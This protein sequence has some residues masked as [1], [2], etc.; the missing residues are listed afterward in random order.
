MFD[1]EKDLLGD[2]GSL[3]L[4]R[5]LGADFAEFTPIDDNTD[6]SSIF[7]EEKKEAQ[8]QP[9]PVPQEPPAE[10]AG[11]APIPVILKSA[12]P[13][14]LHTICFVKGT[15]SAVPLIFELG[16]RSEII[17]SQGFGKFLL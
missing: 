16:I 11:S 8:V 6:M 15:A 13:T 14:N 12:F 5:D 7:G 1:N 3:D 9:E 2:F 17:K 10:N 4:G